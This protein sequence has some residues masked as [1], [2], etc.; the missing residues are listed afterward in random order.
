[1]T[2]HSDAC[3]LKAS[4]LEITLK[5]NHKN[6]Y[7]RRISVILLTVVSVTINIS[8]VMKTSD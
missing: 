4:K 6:A 5:N 2:V 7:S 3:I 8:C 1:M